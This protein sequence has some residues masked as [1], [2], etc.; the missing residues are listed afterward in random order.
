MNRAWRSFAWACLLVAV[1]VALTPYVWIVLTS[2]KSRL[3]ALASVPIWAFAPTF[4]H[5]PGGLHRQGILAAGDQLGAGR[6]VVDG[7][8]L[9]IGVPAAY[10]FARSDFAGKEDLFFFFLTTRMAP[11]ISIVVPMFLFFTSLGLTD[12]S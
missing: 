10:V 8:L 1:V 12:T 7:A 2:F 11:P 6:G 3:D 9:L 5:Y 4:E